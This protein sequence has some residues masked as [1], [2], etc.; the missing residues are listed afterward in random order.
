MYINRR[1]QT[2]HIKYRRGLGVN[3]KQVTKKFLVTKNCCKQWELGW[4]CTIKVPMR[5]LCRCRQN[6]T[7]V[8]LPPLT[9]TSL[10]PYFDDCYKKKSYL[11]LNMTR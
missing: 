11:M 1:R 10:L 2:Y 6:L 9:L 3:L 4:Q 8:T 5:G 7:E